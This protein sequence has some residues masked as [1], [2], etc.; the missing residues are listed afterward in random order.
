MAFK[1]EYVPPLDQ[2][3]SEFFRKARETLRTGYSKHDRW[4]I[5]REREIALVH[6]GSGRE[7]ESANHDRWAYIDR[8]GYCVFSTERLLK[9]EVSSEEVAITHRLNGFWEGE[10]FSVPDAGSLF[11]IKEALREFKDWGLLSDYRRCQLTL[12][13][14]RTG[15]EI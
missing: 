14:G 11:C 9:A 2:E 1:N 3:T 5:D 8:K 4:T 10:R 7:V 12:I 15:E 13:D 6:E